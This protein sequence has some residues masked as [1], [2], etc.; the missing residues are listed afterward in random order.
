MGF[1]NIQITGY[2][3]FACYDSDGT[4]TGFE[5]T[6]PQGRQVRG[7]VGCSRTGCGKGCTV[8]FK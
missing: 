8:R 6:N 5:A 3:A 7:A 1:T 4:C 2:D